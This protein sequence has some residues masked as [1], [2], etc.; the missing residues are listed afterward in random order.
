[1]QAAQNG[2]VSTIT[3]DR[4]KIVIGIGKVL[5]SRTQNLELIVNPDTLALIVWMPYQWLFI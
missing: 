2:K 1:M 5:N 3:T 4:L